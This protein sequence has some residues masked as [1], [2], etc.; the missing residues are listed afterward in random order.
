VN[1]CIE[2]TFLVVVAYFA[3]VGNGFGSSQSY[4]ISFF[5]YAL[6]MYEASLMLICDFAMWGVIWDLRVTLSNS[7]PD[8][9]S[10]NIGILVGF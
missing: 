1:F 10:I 6:I 9:A 8:D 2:F 4:C 5:L 3:L 7:S